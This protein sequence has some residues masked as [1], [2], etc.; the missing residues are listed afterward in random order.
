MIV[1]A[2]KMMCEIFQKDPLC[3]YSSMQ[4]RFQ[5]EGKLLSGFSLKFF[6][7]PL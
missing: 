7:N 5:I 4:I 3:T 6:S 1:C 2:F